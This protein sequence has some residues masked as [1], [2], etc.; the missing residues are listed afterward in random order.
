MGRICDL[1][2]R[3]RGQ[4]KVLL[5][6]TDLSQTQIA[7]KCGVNQCVVSRIKQAMQHGS[8]GTPKRKR[9]CGRRRITSAQ[10]DRAVGSGQD[11]LALD[12][13]IAVW[14]LHISLG[15]FL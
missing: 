15:V 7:L 10:D 12:K 5:E 6:N 2:P 11:W 9:K 8:T 14:L 1:S 4:I 3:K 13:M